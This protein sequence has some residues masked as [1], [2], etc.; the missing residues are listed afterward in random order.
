VSE[1]PIGSSSVDPLLVAVSACLEKWPPSWPGALGPQELG[2]GQLELIAQVGPLDEQRDVIALL[3]GLPLGRLRSTGH[4]GHGDRQG[5]SGVAAPG[6]GVGLAPADV[7]HT[8]RR[9]A[10]ERAGVTDTT[11]KG[12]LRAVVSSVRPSKPEMRRQSSSVLICSMRS[13]VGKR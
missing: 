11:M 4:A 1:H 12:L 9:A 6:E 3:G 7:H 2:S 10:A 8:R 13:L 5:A